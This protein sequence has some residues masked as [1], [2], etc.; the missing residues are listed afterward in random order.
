MMPPPPPLLVS[1]AVA[2]LFDAQ[3]IAVNSR[4][5]G[6]SKAQPCHF[7]FEPRCRLALGDSP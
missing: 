5:V 1:T 7:V 4:H 6:E 2:A 3:E